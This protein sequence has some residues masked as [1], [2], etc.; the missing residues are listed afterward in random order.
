MHKIIDTKVHQFENYRRLAALNLL[1]ILSLTFKNAA[2]S[3]QMRFFLNAMY[4][5]L[6][7]SLYFAV[8]L[9]LSFI[10]FFFYALHSF[11][12]SSVDFKNL[13][14]TSMTVF[15]M[16]VGRQLGEYYRVV[17]EIDFYKALI[18]ILP[19]MLMNFLFHSIFLAI[20]C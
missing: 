18:F 17:R 4:G 7:A 11:G 9:V 6:F 8:I 19:F 15:K 14:Y 10:G 13:S 20:V 2:Q 3:K 1:L 12:Y 5:T 16:F